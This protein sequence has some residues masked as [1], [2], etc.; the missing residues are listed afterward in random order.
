MILIRRKYLKHSENIRED[1]TDHTLIHVSQGSTGLSMPS[2]SEHKAVSRERWH[3]LR[4]QLNWAYRGPT[5]S[6]HKRRWYS[7]AHTT[8]WL[9]LRGRAAVEM[10]Q[11]K[12]SARAGQWLIAPA[13]ERWQ[14]TSE[15]CR[16]LS[17]SFIW[18]WQAGPEL[19][20]IAT[21]ILLE[22]KA[23]PLLKA[24]A[25]QLA[26]EVERNFPGARFQL[27]SK[28]ASFVT[29][30]R[31]QA[32]FDRWLEAYS[33]SL[34]RLGIMPRLLQ[35]KPRVE[36][37]LE[38]LRPSTKPPPSSRELARRLGLSSA[39]LSRLFRQQFSLTLSEYIAQ[40]RLDL[41]RTLLTTSSLSIKETAFR[42]G[43]RSPQHFAR[44]FRQKFGASPSEVRKSAVPII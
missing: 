10:K 17:I 24:A 13:G 27:P 37:A 41:A 2:H 14:E 3:Q 33:T 23:T 36:A 19:F 26:D 42:L 1:R 38:L 31:I 9:V 44:W 43:F 30:L 6:M 21:G 18:R 39:H 28:S 4:A 32:A 16:L 12:W 20:P 7:V 40:Q 8:V 15:D 25:T 29:H 34:I 35:L 22:S 11:G 5:L